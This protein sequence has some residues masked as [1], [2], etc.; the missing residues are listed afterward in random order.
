[1][2]NGLATV[3]LIVCYSLSYIASGYINA[4]TPTVHWFEADD[5]C[6]TNYG[7]HLA[8]ISS[9]SEQTLAFSLCQLL[10][11]GDCWIG[12]NDFKTPDTYLWMANDSINISYSNWNSGYPNHLD[13]SCVYMES[14]LNGEWRDAACTMSLHFIC[15]DANTTKDDG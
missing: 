9:S 12:L 4:T 11:S 3:I 1:M 14:S 10:G 6:L 7:S 13:K 8:T 15:N 5:Y 2:S